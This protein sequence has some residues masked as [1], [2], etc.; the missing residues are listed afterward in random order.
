MTKNKVFSIVIILIALISLLSAIGIVRFAVL[1]LKDIETANFYHGNEKV[2]AK[3]SQQFANYIL[4]FVVCVTN[5]VISI[6]LFFKKSECFFPV[7]YSY[8][9]YKSHRENKKAKKQQA[10]KEKLQKQLYE[11]EKDTE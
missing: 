7:R 8:E 10:K 5:I 3:L 4:C 1:V 2:I 11:I 6:I 9:E